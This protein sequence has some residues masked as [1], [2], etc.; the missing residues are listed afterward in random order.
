LP[1]GWTYES[2]TLTSPLRVDTTTQ[3]AHVTQDDLANSYSLQTS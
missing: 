3:A 2:H 1:T